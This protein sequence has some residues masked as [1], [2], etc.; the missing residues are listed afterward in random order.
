MGETM[1]HKNVLQGGLILMMI[2]ALFCA[3][4]SDNN[5]REDEPAP[6]PETPAP[7]D[8]DEEQPVA[9]P[10]DIGPIVSDQ[11][12]QT[13]DG[14]PG[15]YI[16]TTEQAHGKAT[17]IQ[18]LAAF[19]VVEFQDLGKNRFLVRIKPDPGPEEVRRKAV[20]MPGVQA[21]QP[22]YQYKSQ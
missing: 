16:V 3:C 5:V 13:G 9:E 1:T 2:L 15:E 14:Q 7:A 18:A 11:P 12:I 20:S 4:A 6:A 17:V 10:R 8:D 19:T 21:V 22:N